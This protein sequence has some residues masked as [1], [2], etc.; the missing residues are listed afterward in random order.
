MRTSSVLAIAALALAGCTAK[1]TGPLEGRDPIIGITESIADGPIT[2][3][4]PLS[5]K[6]LTPEHPLYLTPAQ[7]QRID[8]LI[9]AMTVEEKVGQMNQYTSFYD[10]TGPAP[11][12]GTAEE[13]F[14][15]VKA[16][17]VGSMLNVTGAANTRK[18]QELAMQSRL[19]IPIIFGFDVIHGYKTQFPVPLAEAATWDLAL[20]QQAS[21]WAA[22]EASAYG[23]HWTFAPMVDVSP[24]ARWGRIVEGA[25]ED[26]FLGS[27]V[28]AA[29]VRGFQGDDLSAA[30]TIAACTKH[31]AG[32]GYSAAGRDYNIVDVSDYTLHN[33][34]L[35][36]FRAAAEAGSAT[37]MNGFNSLAGIPVTGGKYLQRDWL[38][39][40]LGWPGFIVSDWGSIGEMVAHGYVADNAGAAEM[41]VKAGSDMDM[42]TR[43]YIEELPG[44]VEAGKLKVSTL[45]EAVR[46][47]LRVKMSLG[48]FDDPY[49]YCDPAREASM[50]TAPAMR[51]AAVETA[52]SSAVLLKNEGSLLPLRKAGQ[53]RVVLIGDLANDKDSPLGTWSLGADR[54]SAI[55]LREALESRY[56][57]GSTLNYTA[58]PNTLKSGSKNEFLY[59]LQVN[60]TDRS[61][62]EEAVRAA[63]SADVVVMALG[64]P[65]FMTGEARSRTD[66]RLPGLQQELFDAVQAVNPN[67]VVVLYSGRPLALG[68]V[69]DKARAILLAWQPGSYGNEGIAQV[70][71]G[72]HDADG[73]L[74]VSFPYTVGQEPLTYREYSTGRPGP[75]ARP[76]EQT[77]VFNSHYMDAPRTAQFAFGHGLSY[78][79]FEVGT[80]TLSQNTL[81]TGAPGG[82][83]GILTVTATV[84]NTGTRAGKETVQ[85]YLNDP[86]AKRVRPVKE[87]KAFQSVSLAVGETKTVTFELSPKHLQYWTPEEGWHLEPGTFNIYVGT[88][89]EL[90]GEKLEVAVR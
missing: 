5:L 58:G 83:S 86:V 69:A 44:L 77:I 72:E 39:G 89:S 53:Q 51:A 2:D 8:G 34:I 78:T 16:G 6:P 41:A 27:E 38:K 26:P 68:S 28:A 19:R 87:L 67:V 80:P 71:Y 37:F 30:N 21:R 25:G 36:P 75:S 61:G 12:G 33:D 10:V 43:A 23:I 70:L 35:P 31:F 76:M 42:E 84:R 18:I 11:T 56:A 29:R 57:T 47:I 49:R 40:E 79:T 14:N 50:S 48:L 74:P 62:I 7:E 32:Y 85:L 1:S 9:A 24:D 45:D 4:G 73:K 15:Q 59:E 55:S 46:R 88:S 52:A 81:S 22:V 60:T 17:L 66:I 20:I 90:L 63:R 65:G 13:R 64:E 54:N 3:A 82:A